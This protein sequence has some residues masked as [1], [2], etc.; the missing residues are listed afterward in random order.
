MQRKRPAKGFYKKESISQQ[1]PD[2]KYVEKIVSL[3]E[4]SLTPDAKV[5]HNVHLPVIGQPQREPRRCDAVITY[6]EAP[7]QSFAI[8]EVQKRKRKPEIDKFNGWV[9]KMREV[10]AHMLICVSAQG[11]PESIVSKVA[12]ELG[13]RVKLMTLKQLEETKIGGLIFH[14]P[15]VVYRK[16]QFSIESV[17]QIM[18]KGTESPNLLTMKLNPDSKVFVL[19]DNPEPISLNQLIIQSLNSSSALIEPSLYS[20]EFVF[21]SKTTELRFCFSSEERFKV[22]KFPITVRVEIQNLEIP[23]IVSEYQQKFADDKTLAWIASA[24]GFVEGKEIVIQI[25]FKPDKEGFLQLAAIHQQGS[26][27]LHLILS[28]DKE[29]IEAILIR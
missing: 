25:V 19:G 7:R 16:R 13:P 12:T 9:E 5:E 21:D 27:S 3:L 24:K 28:P 17:G 23:L 22:L 18:L 2:W 20:R 26:E 8:V 29:A 6:G 10:G 1:E 4:K 14:F 15:F 11:Y